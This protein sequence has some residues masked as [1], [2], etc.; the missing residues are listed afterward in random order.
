MIQATIVPN[1]TCQTTVG[2][3]TASGVSPV[4]RTAR[5]NTPVVAVTFP[6][7]NAAQRVAD[8]TTLV[9][10]GTQADCIS[11]GSP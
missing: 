4:D 5:S 10:G 8:T 11:P 6:L 2:T 3:Q 7:F 9:D 1:G